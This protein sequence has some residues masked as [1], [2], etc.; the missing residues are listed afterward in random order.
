[1]VLGKP[2]IDSTL[3][4]FLSHCHIHNYTSK[5]TL[6]Y[7]GEKANTLYYLIK[8]SVSIIIKNKE[9]KEM[10]LSYLHQDNFIGELGLFNVS[11]E[12]SAWVRTKTACEVAEISY[13]KFRHLIQVNPD[14]LLRLASQMA[15]RL[16]VT[17]E[18]VGNL[19]F[20]DVTKR[21]TQTLLDLSKQPDAMTHPDGMQ[22]KITRQEIGQI[23]GCSRETVGRVLKIL[24][25]QQILS[26]Y[27]KTIVIY[28][29]R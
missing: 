3:E 17:S 18:K 21:I 9:G 24:E 14:I 11:K 25:N 1:M 8:G 2:P 4:W 15:N 27:G 10:I 20:C 12:R 7:Q 19:A 28:G 6:I 13:S 22:I 29:T 5:S 16:Q 26:A 23:V